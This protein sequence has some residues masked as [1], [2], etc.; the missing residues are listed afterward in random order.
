MLKCV[1]SLYSHCPDSLSNLCLVPRRSTSAQQSLV[2]LSLVSNPA[3]LAATV[4]SFRGR[5]FFCLNPSVAL[6][7]LKRKSQLLYSAMRRDNTYPLPSLLSGFS[8]P[9]TFYIIKD[10]LFLISPHELL[11]SQLAPYPSSLSNRLLFIRW[12]SVCFPHNPESSNYPA[13]PPLTW[14]TCFIFMI[15]KKIQLYIFHRNIFQLDSNIVDRNLRSVL[16][17]GFPYW[18]AE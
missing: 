2:F 16:I 13:T 6:H 9:H 18:W 17:V 12:E 14:I 4:I 11:N 5:S 10:G 8:P 15:L 1:S 7:F 3:P